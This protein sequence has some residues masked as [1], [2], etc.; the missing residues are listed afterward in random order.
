M[1]AKVKA[2]EEKYNEASEKAEEVR[3][4]HFSP[5]LCQASLIRFEDLLQ[6]HI[7]RR[8]LRSAYG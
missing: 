8:I 4:P 1:E 2:A 6:E 3:A 5:S 7:E